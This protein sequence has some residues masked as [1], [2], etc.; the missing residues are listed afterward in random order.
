MKRT[1]R[2]FLITAV[3]APLAAGLTPHGQLVTL[4]APMDFDNP[5]LLRYDAHCFTFNNQDTLVMSAAFHYPRCPQPLWRDRLQKLKTAGFNTIETYVFWN[6][7]EREEGKIDLSEFE[8]FVQLVHEMGFMMIVRPGPFISADWER[9]GFPSWVAAKRFPLRSNDPQSVATSRHWYSAILP[10]IMK[11]QIM[12]GGPIIM[13]QIENEYDFSPPMRDDAKRE[14]IRALAQMVWSAGITIPVFTCWTRQAR[15][16]GD[17][18]MARIID[19]CNFY[20]RWKIVE[21]L[22]PAL[23]KLR[24]E[25]P[26]SPLAISELQGG[27]FSTIGGVLGVEQEGTD[28]RNRHA[29]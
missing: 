25:E 18:D 2:D 29:Y 6:Y 3:A 11:N 26:N 24:E 28:A 27:W 5:H 8:A 16:N 21:N 22:T 9:G 14:Y 17:S 13:V 12:L 19:T 23:K 20:P 1:R 10:V 15:E 7:H 4:A